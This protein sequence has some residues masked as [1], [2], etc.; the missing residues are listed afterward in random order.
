MQH[1]A[2]PLAGVTYAPDHLADRYLAAGAWWSMTVGDALRKTALANPDKM[3]VISDDRSLTFR[4]FDEETDRLGAALLAMG[5]EPGDRAM[6]QLGTTVETAVA[7]TACYKA[8]IVPVCAVPQY[9]DIE[10]GQLSRMSNCRAYLV[11]ADLGNFDLV[12]FASRMMTAH[13][14]IE[15]LVTVRGNGP[16]DISALIASQSLEEARQRLATVKL[17]PGDVLSFQLSGGTTGVPKIIPRFHGEYLGHSAGWRRC[18]GI[19]GNCRLIWALQL[20]HNAGQVYALMSMLG[21]GMSLVLMPRVDVK[22]MLELIELHRVSHALSVG[23]IAP[24]L[25]AYT[26]LDRHDLSSLQLFGTMTRSDSLEA[27]IG[28]PCSNQYG[29]TEGLVLGTS[30]NDPPVLR[31]KTHGYSGEPL[32]EISLRD[33]VGHEVA[34][35]EIG[36]LYFR[37]PYSLRAYYNAP[38]ATAETVLPDGFVRSGDMMR[39]HRL[40]TLRCYSFEGRIKDNV[41]RGGEKIGA[42]EVEGLVSQHPAVADAKLV[43]MPDPIYGEKGCIYLILRAGW[44]A[45][46]IAELA[47]FLTDAG[48]AKFKCPERI[49]IIE[50]FPVTRVGKLDKAALRQMIAARLAVENEANSKKRGAVS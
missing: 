5:L 35:G 6:V 24:Q 36:E 37:G 26:E 7:L 40:G 20:V 18:F 29:L 47:T 30:A 13:P 27:H 48:L 11:Q 16:D 10:I 9:R 38:E 31:Y 14:F 15:H 45:P 23:P 25:I 3:A 32:D 12:A 44:P 19:D 4:Q 28:V 33:P 21:E 17:L 34:T 50:D 22:R 43:A 2:Y 1:V 42:E 41:N 8:G 49:E 46:S 39:E